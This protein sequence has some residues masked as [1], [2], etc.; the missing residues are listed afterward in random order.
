MTEITTSNAANSS[1]V[2]ILILG[3]GWLYQF[4]HPLL[5]RSSV[6][7][8]GTTRDGRANTIPFTFDPASTDPTPYTLLPRAT[9]ILI[10]FPLL[11]P[12]APHTLRDLY[13]SAHPT[14]SPHYILLGSTGEYKGPGWH[15][16]TSTPTSNPPSPRWQAETALLGL[17]GCVLNLAG[18]M[19]EPERDGK[20][21]ARAVPRSK[22]GVREKGS[23]HF[24]HGADVARGVLAVHGRFEAGKGRRWMLTDGRVYDWWD[25][26]W[27]NADG[28]DGRQEA[29]KEGGY[30]AWVAELMREEGVRALP[31]EGQVLGR[32]LDSRAFWEAFKLVPQ[33]RGFSWAEPPEDTGVVGRT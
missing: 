29:P 4:L 21:W 23:V 25:L 14:S 19:G 13:A 8:V 30:R 15:D 12:S 1:T 20:I 22:D 11:G 32:R 7:H 5:T 2:E 31:R 27:G 33:A 17:G 6:S 3:A 16:H 28:L 9:T 18:L 10:T 26:I 24:I